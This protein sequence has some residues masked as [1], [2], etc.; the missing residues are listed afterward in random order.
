MARVGFLGTGE[1]AAAMVRGLAGE[2]HSVLVSERNATISARLEREVAGVAVAP[3]AEVV[4]QSDIVFVCLLA[5]VARSVLPDLPW[6]AGQTVI[7]VMVDMPLREVQAACAPVSD[8][9]VTI[10]LPTIAH[11][12]C[13]LPVFPECRTLESLFGDTN[14]VIPVA[15]EAALAAHFAI[16]GSLAAMLD[17]FQTLTDWLAFETG[18][19]EAA[20]AYVAALYASYMQRGDRAEGF[21]DMAKALATPGGLN[22]TLQAHMARAGAPSALREA[23]DA[24]RPRLGLPVRGGL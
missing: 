7:S 22:A 18:D 2:G 4:S 8:V 14:L 9:A 13:P 17:L 5:P 10:P 1:I 23:L 6:S 11:G 16:G 3:N 20:D 19:E 15:S 21:R 24:L 12:G